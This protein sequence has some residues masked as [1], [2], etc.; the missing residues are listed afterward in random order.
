MDDDG[1]ELLDDEYDY[2]DPD[3][4]Y[5]YRAGEDPPWCCWTCRDSRT[6]PARRGHTRRCPSCDPNWLG[7]QR[8]RWWWW[9]L[10]MYR[11][12]MRLRRRQHDDPPF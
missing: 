12:W 7:R 5:D 10:R 4:D 8:H 2:Y 6:V 3:A 1:G 9:R 11:R